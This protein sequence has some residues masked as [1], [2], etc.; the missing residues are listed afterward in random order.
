MK[1]T[2]L[3]LLLTALPLALLACSGE[4]A[5]P[6]APG[7]PAVDDSDLE[8][9]SAAVVGF[10]QNPYAGSGVTAILGQVVGDG[11]PWLVFWRTSDAH[12]TWFK[13]G[14]GSFGTAISV[15]V[16]NAAFAEAVVPA[17]GQSKG[18]SCSNFGLSWTL[19][20]PQQGS[21]GFLINGSPGADYFN[22]SGQNNGAS[23]SCFGNFGNDIFDTQNPNAILHG[24]VGD[25]K[26]RAALPTG[27][28]PGPQLF[29]DEDNDCLDSPKAT[30]Y[31]CGSGTGDRSTRVQGAGCE[32]LATNCF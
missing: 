2:P 8:T 11:N 18:V 9:R 22:C 12:C 17:S 23:V 32:S 4:A 13:V 25:D 10:F 27:N 7:L 29:G 16:T 14:T 6:A 31:D 5:H 1:P 24:G 20:M 15:D 30:V 26:L 3:A 21:F 28:S 19:Q